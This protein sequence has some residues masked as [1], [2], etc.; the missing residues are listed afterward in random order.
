MGSQSP[1]LIIAVLFSLVSSQ[2][3]HQIIIHPVTSFLSLHTPT[4]IYTGYPFPTIKNQYLHTFQHVFF[5]YVLLYPGHTGSPDL[6][7]LHGRQVC[8]FCGTQVLQFTFTIFHLCEASL[9]SLSLKS[10][11]KTCFSLSA[12]FFQIEMSILVNQILAIPTQGLLRKYKI[13]NVLHL[14]TSLYFR[15][16]EMNAGPNMTKIPN[17]VKT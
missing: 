11:R 1:V 7:T 2:N 8:Q 4:S 6:G 9:K 5:F 13:F 17:I 14:Q 10:L 12:F 15:V 3:S 16:T